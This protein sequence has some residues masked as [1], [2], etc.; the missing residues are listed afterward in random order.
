MS[1]NKEVTS[2]MDQPLP[3]IGIDFG[4]TNSKM[5]WF[6]PGS[7]EQRPGPELIR[8][9]EGEEHTPSLVYYC[10]RETLVGRPALEMLKDSDRLDGDERHLEH[11]RFVT[12]V[13]RSLITP[14]LIPLPGNRD[15]RPVDVVAEILRKLKRDAEEL[16]FHNQK[17]ERCVITYPAEFDARQRKKI[18]EGAHLAGF[19]EIKMLAEPVAA[20]LAFAQGGYKVGNGVLVYDLGGGT[21]D[22]A[23]VARDDKGSFRLAMETDGD[24][25]CGGDDFDQ[26]LY[27]YWN[28]QAQ[29]QLGRTISLSDNLV[30]ISFLNECRNRKEMLSKRERSEFSS[31]LPGGKRF[32]L[33]IT[34]A[35]FENLVRERL[36]KTVERTVSMVQRIKNNGHQVD[37]IVLIGGSSE[38][39]LVQQILAERL[40]VEPL[41]WQYRDWAVVLGATYY[42]QTLWGE[43]SVQPVAQASPAPSQKVEATIIA[44]PTLAAIKQD[45]A[46][47][48][49]NPYKEVREA[50]SDMGDA[51]A[52]AF[53][54]GSIVAKE[55][56]DKTRVKAKVV[57]GKTAVIAKDVA[58]QASVKAKDL[59]DK[60]AIATT[61]AAKAIREGELKNVIN[62]QQDQLKKSCATSMLGL[63]LTV[64]GLAGLS[65]GPW[66]AVIILV[67]LFMIYS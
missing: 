52:R 23:F 9:A 58:G 65:V 13:K 53:D 32:K 5:A 12:S 28:R 64:V 54:A 46:G 56:A 10:V 48:H 6:N 37:T 45:D 24:A 59:S 7:Q 1:H 25:L 18:E 26:A 35:T 50:A 21:F 29:Q 49:R 11:Q 57:A 66:S 51:A 33:E 47:Q 17:V 15:V 40:K 31:L 60:A 16:H 55:M 22:L 61:R 39:P 42:A 38:I 36:E 4:T 43:P 8:N 34:R 2:Q 63:L 30:D 19:Q 14:P 41:R 67:G 20:A 62:A 27:D 3:F 44:Q